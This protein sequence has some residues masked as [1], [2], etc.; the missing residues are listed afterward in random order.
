MRSCRARFAVLGFC[1]SVLVFGASAAAA[2]PRK[3]AILLFPGAEVIDYAGPYEVF[4][5]AGFDVYTVATTKRPVRTGMG[6]VVTP[7]YD[8]ASAP[9]ADIVLIPGGD[10]SKASHDSA[11]LGWI[12]SQTAHAEVTMSICNAAS[13]LAN[14]GLLNGLT[15]TTTR[16]NIAALRA[17]H[18]QIHVVGDQR[19]VD[20]GKIM[21]TGGLTAGIDGAVHVVSRFAG[22]GAAENTALTLEYDAAAGRNYL[23]ATFAVNRIPDVG[24]DLMRLGTWNITET[25]GD[26][27]RWTITAKGQSKLTAQNLMTRIN[28]SFANKRW[29]RTDDHRTLLSR[30]TFQDP[31]QSHW[32]GRLLLNPLPGQSGTFALEITVNRQRS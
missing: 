32:T 5:T 29:T 25:R 20:N 12:K 6:L 31:D 16:T 28:A 15:A 21:T 4:I 8:F 14:T 23:P 22:E 2:P 3:V 13:L 7:T 17:A 26:A 9:Q 24:D 27:D 1:L 10:I 18:P 30:W 19:F 11:I